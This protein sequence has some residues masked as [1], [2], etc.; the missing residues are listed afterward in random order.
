MSVDTQGASAAGWISRQSLFFRLALLVAVPLMLLGIAA[1]INAQ[2]EYARA[3][4]DALAQASVLARQAAARL[5]EHYDELD[6]F[7][8]A[9]AEVARWTLQHG[10]DGDPALAR[11]LH[12]MPQHVTGLSI[13]SLSGAMVASTTAAVE[14]RAM[15][16]LADRAY[17]K[18]TVARRQL[19]IGEPVRSRTSNHWVSIAGNPVYDDAGRVIGVVSSSTRLDRI[20]TML[21][22]A[23]LPLGTLMTVF[24]SRGVGIASTAEPLAAIGRDFAQSDTLRRVLGERELNLK[25]PASDGQQRYVAYAA[26]EKLPWI[27]EVGLPVELTLAPAKQQLHERLS[28]LAVAL[29]LGLAVAALLSRRIGRP[30][31]A[32]VQDVDELGKGDLTRRTAVGGYHEV[33][34]LG[35]AF[36]RMAGAIAAQREAVRAS[37]Q[38]FRSLV[39]LSTDWY[40][41]QDANL[42]FTSVGTDNPNWG[43]PMLGK[44]R[45]ELD[46]A[47]LVGTWADHQAL[48]ERHESFRDVEFRYTGAHGVTAYLS[49]SG[50]PVYDAAGAFCG[51][52]G[53]ATDVTERVRL[54]SE[55]QERIELLRV[56]LDTVPVA[57]G[58]VRTRDNIALLT[59]RAAHE[60]LRVDPG[61][62]EW[63]VIDYWGRREDAREVKRRIERDGFVRDMEVPVRVADREGVWALMSAQPARYRG[64]AVTVVTLNDITARKVLE[65]QSKALELQRESLLANLRGANERLRLLS[66]QVLD[67][68]EAERRQIAHELHDEIGQNLTALKLFAGH[69]RGRLAAQNQPEVDEWI[70]LLNRAIEQV[71]DL[72]RLLRPVQ[73]DHMGLAAALRALLDTQARAAGW[74]VDFV[75]DADMPRLDM[76]HETVAYRVVQEA[77]VNVARHAD[78]AR[79]SLELKLADG[80]LMLKLADDGRGFD[81]EAARLRVAQGR[82]MGLLGMEERVRLAGGTFHIESAP[83]QGTRIMVDIPI[84]SAGNGA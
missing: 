22:P 18:D 32:L 24:N 3:G 71:R 53:T 41:E 57:I 77:L 27:V 66:R 79:V 80:Q 15:I 19:T 67:A 69:L 13:L 73:L 21:V 56:T 75:A 62:R 35:V 78:A 45:W 51:Y 37:E 46:G 36:N 63:S 30:M 14:A 31:R 28:L 58:V 76:R 48:L 44:T 25:A 84:A 38:R 7:L 43:R 50:E 72:S 9:V 4:Q 26:G 52:R 59:N 55:L 65:A 20:S 39:E 10:T 61:K 82:S 64:E 68:Q 54:Q 49:V 8:T 12:R 17:F 16:N 42:R 11:M 74:T 70:E 5:D 2:R 47:P 6:Q 1:V 81:V 29:M 83:T 60:L 23:G 33:N 40:W 34:R